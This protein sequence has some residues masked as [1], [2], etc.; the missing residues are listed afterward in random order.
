M[1]QFNELFSTV[2]SHSTKIFGILDIA[3]IS[4]MFCYA[5]L[6]IWLPDN[7]ECKY[8]CINRFIQMLSGF[9]VTDHIA[10]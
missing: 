1:A 2:I 3:H 6:K 7:C 4:V 10:R 9:T 8:N 5:R